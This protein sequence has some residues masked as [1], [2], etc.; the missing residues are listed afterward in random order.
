MKFIKT[1]VTRN[2]DT[3]GINLIEEGDCRKGD[4]ILA[5]VIS[6]GK[7]YGYVRSPKAEKI[8]LKKGDKVLLCLSDRYAARIMEGIVP[9]HLKKGEVISIL[10]PGG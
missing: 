9:K 7:F 6:P 1:A 2:V 5:K 10:E 4:I 8:Y 3:E